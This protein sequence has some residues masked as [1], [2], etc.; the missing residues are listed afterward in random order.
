[1]ATVDYLGPYNKT[2]NLQPG[3]SF[4]FS[5]ESEAFEHC[6][7]SITAT[8]RKGYPFG[9]GTAHVLRVE[10]VNVTAI[11]TRIAGSEWTSAEF[12]AG[13]NITNNGTTT[14][15]EWS[16]VVAVIRP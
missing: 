13:C 2:V 5:L 15:T 3:E 7:L 14:I 12:H 16:I 9:P 1:M 4:W 11:E 6:A 10:N 8:P